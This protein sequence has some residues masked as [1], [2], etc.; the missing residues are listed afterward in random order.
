M[1][2]LR[3]FF[4]ALSNLI[5]LR[6]SFASVE[7]QWWSTQLGKY[8]TGQKIARYNGWLPNVLNT[9]HVLNTYMHVWL[10]K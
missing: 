6:V 8:A 2:S 10:N 7:L 4:Q 3:V 9:P 5:V 1:P